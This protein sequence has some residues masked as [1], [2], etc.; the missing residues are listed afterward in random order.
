MERD[1]GVSF[2]PTRD[3]AE[4]SRNAAGNEGLPAAIQ[5]LSLRLP[6]ILGAQAPLDSSLLKNR[7]MGGLGQAEQQLWQ[8]LQRIMG[9]GGQPPMGGMGGFPQAPQPMPGMTP[10]VGPVGGQRPLPGGPGGPRDSGGPVFPPGPI[11]E[12]GPR[13]SVENPLVRGGGGGRGGSRF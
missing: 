13:F 2:A 4:Q 12:M 8:V 5:M 6:R 3:N 10:P 1:L 9:G 11:P 7:G